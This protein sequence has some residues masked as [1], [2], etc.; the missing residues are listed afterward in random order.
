M[1]IPK[2]IFYLIAILTYTS[3]VAQ[4]RD[5]YHFD[6]SHQ[7]RD[8]KLKIKNLKHLVIPDSLNDD[9]KDKLNDE[10]D[11]IIDNA[12]DILD[13]LEEIEDHKINAALHQLSKPSH[14]DFDHSITNKNYING[15]PSPIVG[16]SYNPSILF[17]HNSGIYTQF[18]IYQYPE[19]VNINNAIPE[20]DIMVGFEKS[21]TENLYLDMNY[22][23][24][25]LTYGTKAS[26]Q[27]M[28]NNLTLSGSYDFDI[29]SLGSDFMYLYGGGTNLPSQQRQSTLVNFYID[30]EFSFNHL[31]G[32]Y[33]CS[34]DPE[35]TIDMG[36][37]NLFQVR[38]KLAG[39]QV[40]INKKGKTVPAAIV[41]NFWGLLGVDASLNLSYKIRNFKF[42]FSPHYIVPYNVLNDK[43]VRQMGAS[44]NIFYFTTGITYRFKL[45]NE[46]LPEKKEGNR[47]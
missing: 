1:I 18:M 16:M 39:E 30:K 6:E 35:L 40:I 22:T 19:D 45:W 33:Y 17:K 2:Y 42:Y 47:Q 7:I 41:D 37:D 21:V 43:N 8:I 32:S 23:Y 46:P 14:F 4:N 20:W 36:N 38:K 31:L 5:E 24:S 3:I 34:L 9:K 26:Q 25:K 12:K 11:S 13:S 27:L 29:I 44:T 28:A 10:K 15:R